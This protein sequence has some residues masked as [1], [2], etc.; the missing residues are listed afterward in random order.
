MADSRP[1]RVASSRA[2]YF[3]RILGG[4]LVKQLLVAS[5]T[6]LAALMAPLSA[7]A[8]D[9]G[10]F[11]FSGV[12][13]Q[14]GLLGDPGDAGANGIGFGV[15]AA[16]QVEEN[17]AFDIR[18]LGSSHS[19]VDHRDLSVGAEYYFG[20]Y[21]N[22]YPHAEVGMSFL[23]NE[24][25][26]ADVSG[27][28]VGLYIGGGLSFELSKSLMIGPEV[29]FVKAFEAETTINNQTVSTV[30]DSYSLLIRLQYLLGK[31]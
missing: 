14:V 30:E 27:D 5:L 3:S 9:K 17:L 13:G 15:G 19:E 2:S 23:S 18:Y 10:L 6:A 25:K 20:D 22:A 11:R 31:D 4:L 8:Y 7:S 24:I 1:V 12:L 21:T 28:A 26:N 16:Y 29:R